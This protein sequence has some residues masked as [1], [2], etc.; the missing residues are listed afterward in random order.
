[1]AD[2]PKDK[3]GDGGEPNLEE[4]VKKAVE[5]ETQGLKRKNGEL[6]EANKK[7][8][9]RLR[10]FGDLDP[11]EVR[12]KLDAYDDLTAGGKPPEGGEAAIQAAVI[13]AQRKA[14]RE[15]ERIEATLAQT[16]EALDVAMQKGRDFLLNSA[17]DGAI[18]EV[19]IAGPYREAVR[20]LHRDK[21]ATALADE[22]E[23]SPEAAS[24]IAN[25]VL[26]Q[27]VATDMG[28]HYV[29]A[30]VTNGG[31]AK[32]SQSAAKGGVAGAKPVHQMTER[33]KAQFVDEHGLDAFKTLLNSSP[34]TASANAA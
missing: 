5:R 7:Y 34:G 27:F 1:M 18:G 9:E 10:A 23:M 2:E 28:K 26:Q 14:D 30:P 3:D 22:P 21:V 12:E 25:D 32:G 29:G 33:D 13:R 15:R 6:L 24:R 20:L 4:M 8:T 19:G 17:L 16:K 11:E 31:G